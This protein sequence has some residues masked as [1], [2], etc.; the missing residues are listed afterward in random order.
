VAVGR[1]YDDLLAGRVAVDEAEDR[2]LDLLEDRE[3][4]NGFHHAA[5][6]ADWVAAE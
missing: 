1:V 4:A 5:P 2:L 6:G 3:V